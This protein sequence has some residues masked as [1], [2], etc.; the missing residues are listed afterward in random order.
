MNSRIA[1]VA[2]KQSQV[3]ESRG[4][5]L[6]HAADVKLAISEGEELALSESNLAC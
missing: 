3:L 1:V 2:L 5:V 4:E 6:R